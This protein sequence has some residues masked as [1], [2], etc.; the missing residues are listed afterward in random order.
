MRL[1]EGQTIDG[2]YL[3]QRRIGSGGMADVWLAR[4]SELGRDVAIKVLHENF[5]RDSEFVDRFRRE[6][7]AAAGLQHPNVVAVFDR[8]AVEDTYYIAM[9]Y[10]EGSTLRDLISRGLGISESVEVTRQVLAAAG[11]AHE[12]GFV[13]RDLKPMNVLIDRSGRVRVTDF[14]IARA[15][16]S[17]ITRTGSVLGTAQYLSPEQAQGFEVTQTSDIYSIGVM[18]FEMLTGR[19]PFDGDNAVA[20]A[21]KQVSETPP[22]PSTINP[23]VPAALDSVVLK[24]LAK[25]PASRYGSAAEMLHAL[26]AAEANPDIAGHTERYAAYVPPEERESRWKWWALG[27]L[28]VLLVGFLIWLLFLRGDDGVR[29]PAVSGQSE[30]SARLELQRAGFEVAVERVQNEAPESTVLEQDPRAGERAEEGTTVTITVSLGPAPVAVPDVVGKTEAFAR[31]KLR[32]AGFEVNVEERASDSTPAGR[33]IDTDPAGGTEVAAGETVTLIVS[34]GTNA[35]SVPSVVGLDRFDAEAQLEDAGFVVN[36]EPQNDDAPED[37]VIRQ[38][39]AGGSTASKG[40]E[41]TIVYSTGAGS[42]Q[43][44]S[45]VGQEEA[46]AVSQLE[47][48]GLDVTVDR[49]DTEDPSEDGI[50][51]S[52]SPS[53]GRVTAGSLVRLTVGKYVKPE[54]PTTT[55]TDP[56][57]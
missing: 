47:A 7:S 11:F 29:V 14:G 50:V 2:R 46:Y 40:D 12:R 41:V 16:N 56:T 39:P 9:E 30:T 13:H 17:E 31:K 49:V 57:P 1:T 3:L 15:G 28:A 8:G 52:Q 37:Q 4:D 5:A 54:E 19:V 34:R 33:V 25:D 24:A 48:A 26:D 51:L 32:K 42:V 6:A 35:V 43:V 18:L 22:A 21:M 23:A 44:R 27:A 38:I 55:T 10:V 45:Y 53:S 20:I 36:T